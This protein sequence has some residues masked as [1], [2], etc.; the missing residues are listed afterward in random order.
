MPKSK[1]VANAQ[2]TPAVVREQPKSSPPLP[3]TVVQ[4]LIVPVRVEF[5]TDQ[6]ARLRQ[7]LN[8]P[9]LVLAWNNAEMSRPSAFA[10]GLDG[11]FG[12]QIG[13]NA[14]HCQKGWDAHK[15]ALLRET[16]E[17]KPSGTAPQETYPDEATMEA[18]MARQLALKVK[19]KV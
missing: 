3:P 9:I 16:V 11:Q 12:L 8:D 17:R 1:K 18:E 14:L 2:V 10:A 4:G 6:R 13:N 5:T 7:I 19:P 15:A